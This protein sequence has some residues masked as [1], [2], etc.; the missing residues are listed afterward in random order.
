M[1]ASNVLAN[2][3]I[4]LSELRQILT[5]A[6]NYPSGDNCQPFRFNWNGNE[7]EIEYETIRGQ[8]RLNP[9]HLISWM[10]LGFLLEGMD[11][12]ASQLGFATEVTLPPRTAYFGHDFGPSKSRVS[13]FRTG[14]KGDPLAG[15]LLQR[16][17]D[18]REFSSEPLSADL[19]RAAHAS[20]ATDA[21]SSNV[22]LSFISPK[23]PSDLE[24]FI[25]AADGLIWSNPK[26]F[27]D[28]LHWMRLTDA[29][30]ANQTDGMP[31]KTLGIGSSER[32]LLFRLKKYPFLRNLVPSI[33]LRLK[34]RRILSN[35]LRHTGALGLFTVSSFDSTSLIECGRSAMRCWLFLNST[36]YGFQPITLPA[37]A[38][39]A[40]RVQAWSEPLDQKWQ[41]LFKSGSRILHD[42]FALGSGEIP[43][44]MFRTGSATAL[45]E[46][47]R[48]PRRSID[49]LFNVK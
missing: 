41:N 21:R 48:T 7:L 29:E 3:R 27:V 15:V 19:L 14:R 9:K 30:T 38:P 12:A 20:S 36:G 17:T 33:S 8:H 47:L 34:S 49:E 32:K 35:Q 42:S 22:K 45:P 13:F 39:I 37:F 11:L 16:C 2:Q 28:L 31:W 44:W 1:S 18:R 43:L 23:F 46:E 26:T 40:T 6:R 5:L 10:T 24:K 4:E 25:F